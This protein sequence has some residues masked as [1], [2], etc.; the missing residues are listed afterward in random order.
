MKEVKLI[1][2]EGPDGNTIEDI[3]AEFWANFKER[4]KVNFPDRGDDA[5]AYFISEVILAVGG[6]TEAVTSYFMT[7]VP[8]AN[9]EALEDTLAQANLK[10]DMFHAYLLHIATKPRHLRVINF[11]GN[12]QGTFIATGV[13]MKAFDAI[14]KASGAGVEDFMAALF[15][16]ANEG[17]IT[18]SGNMPKR[19][20]LPR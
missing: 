6:G 4:C 20:D 12:E 2:N 14:E 16:A 8:R 19:E 11:N 10:W 15:T 13:P 5:W 17:Q 18:L 3:P 1:I 7:D 9:A